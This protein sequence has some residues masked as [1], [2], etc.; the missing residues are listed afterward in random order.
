[1][2]TLAREIGAWARLVTR[3]V[4]VTD[5]EAYSILMF[6][7]GGLL[8]TVLAATAGLPALL[9]YWGQV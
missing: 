3:R 1:M 4:S 5:D 7:C 6:S 2:T 8:L 9:R